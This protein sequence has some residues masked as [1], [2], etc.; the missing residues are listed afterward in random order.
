MKLRFWA[1][2]LVALV[3]VA[4]VAGP[5]LFSATIMAQVP[6]TPT[7]TTTQPAKPK[8]TPVPVQSTTRA[9]SIGVPGALS[10]VLTLAGATPYSSTP[11]GPAVG[12]IPAVTY[13]VATAL[14]VL[15]T[16]GSVSQVQLPGPPNGLVGWV[17]SSSGTITPDPWS[18][19][20]SLS[21]RTITVYNDG[22]VVATAPAAVGKPATPT[23]S[24][25]TFVDGDIQTVGV[26][27]AEAPVLRTLGLHQVGRAAAI[28]QRAIGATQIAIH[29]W[30]AGTVTGPRANPVLWS[31][32]G[33]G[34]A[35]S[36]GCIRVPVGAG[37]LG[38]IAKVPNG[39]RVDVLP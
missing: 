2:A 37:V 31:P 25:W 4:V 13:G 20:V 36:H 29:G 14:P 33:H 19:V 17:S 27:A 12:T 3:A 18:I 23:P 15:A 6:P 32:D 38:S 35:I 11:G 30:F 28:D 7:T 26:D 9:T 1:V 24:G 39:T 10:P 16:Q 8:A 21:A 34:H 5:T 22:R